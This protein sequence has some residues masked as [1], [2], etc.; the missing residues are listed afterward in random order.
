MV[1]RTFVEYGIA[2]DPDEDDRDIMSFGQPKDNVVEMVTVFG[3]LPVG[4]AILTS[5]GDS[6]VKLTKLYLDRNF[7]GF[8]AGRAMLDTAVATAKSMGYD[9]IFLKTR[10]LYKE[11]VELYESTGWARGADQPGP[12]PDRMY[13]IIFPKS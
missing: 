1:F 13:Y 2:A 9:E 6:R 5:N 7:R 4:S 8:G 11:A 12:G 10:A 3:D